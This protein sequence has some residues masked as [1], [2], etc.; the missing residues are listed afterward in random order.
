MQYPDFLI[1]IHSFAI[2]VSI[3]KFNF[4]RWTTKGVSNPEMSNFPQ[5]QG[6]RGIVRRRTQLYA[7]QV[8]PKIYPPKFGG[9]LKFEL[10]QKLG[11]KGHLWMETNWRIHHATQ[12]NT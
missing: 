2:V 7:A 11:K 10:T 3:R 6:K 9:G 1:F 4:K 5:D 8:I 12:T